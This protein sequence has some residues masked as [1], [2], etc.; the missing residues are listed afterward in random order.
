M[1]SSLM[2][3]L[4][5]A[6]KADQMITAMLKADQMITAMLKADQMITAMLKAQLAEAVLVV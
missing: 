6:S 3:N 5:P 2:N 1:C 4:R